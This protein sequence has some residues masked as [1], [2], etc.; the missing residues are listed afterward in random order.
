[1][2]IGI[3]GG[4]FDPPHLGHLRA[5]ELARESFCLDRIWFMVAKDPP[6]KKERVKSPF[7]VRFTMASLAVE[8]NP[9]F[10]V[11]DFEAG[12]GL[13]YT[14]DTMKALREVYPHEFFLIVG[15]DSFE[16]FPTWKD[17]R[18][19]VRENNIVVIKRKWTPFRPP[20]W[21]SDMGLDINYLHEGE[22][23]CGKGI[24]Y[25]SC[26]TLPISSS[27]VREKVKRGLSVR[28]LVPEKVRKY[29]LKEVLYR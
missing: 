12:R 3:Y 16:E 6:H 7:S 28:Y 1:M 20:A 26:A 17:Y 9:H 5:A 24:F 8:E 4:T 22:R 18:T 19:L 29:I 13:S 2:R 21:A 10:Q 11:S 23:N 15:E 14:V 25:L 27:M